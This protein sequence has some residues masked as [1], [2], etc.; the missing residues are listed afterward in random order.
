MESLR[1]YLKTGQFGN[2]LNVEGLD[3]LFIG[4]VSANNGINLKLIGLQASG[5]SNFKVEKIRVS[6]EPLIKVKHF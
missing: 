1:P 5:I 2:G 3:P 4:D 6:L